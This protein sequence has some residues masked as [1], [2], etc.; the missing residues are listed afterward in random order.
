ASA[1]GVGSLPNDWTVAGTGDFD[2]DGVWDILWFN[3]TSGG[4]AAWLMTPMGTV[5]AAV[6]VG[7]LPAG[8]SLAG[9]GDFNGDNISDILLTNTGNGVAIWF[10][11]A[12]ATVGSAQGVGTM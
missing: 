5:K 2:G 10:M 1:I 9:T 12:M 8:F 4:V 6:G 7:S 11:T 3:S